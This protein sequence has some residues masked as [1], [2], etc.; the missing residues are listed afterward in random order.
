MIAKMN[1]ISITGPKYD[2][3]RV[4]DTYLSKHEIH[5]ENALQ[6]LNTAKELKPYIESNPYKES[7]TKALDLVNMLDDASGPSTDINVDY[8]TSLVD[9]ITS[10]MK[11][12][13]DQAD[14]LKQKYDSLQA[15]YNKIAPFI[16]LHYDVSKIIHFDYIRYRFGRIPREYWSK[17]KDYVYEDL[18]TIF[19]ECKYDDDYV[20]GIYFV[21][22]AENDKVDAIYTSL[23]FERTFIPDEY[24]GTPTEACENLQRQMNEVSLEIGEMEQ[25]IANTL[26]Y[27]KPQILCAYRKI[28]TASDNFDYRK[29]A[30]CTK[31]GDKI[32]YILCGWIPENEAKLLDQETKDD[33]D[34]VVILEGSDASEVSTPPTK[35]QNKGIFKPFEMFIRMYGLPAYDEFDPTIFV[36]LTYAFIFGAMFGDVGQGL[37][38]FIGGLLLYKFKHIPLAAIVSCAGICSTFFGFMFGSIFGFENII[39]PVWLRPGAAMTN[40]RGIGS[41][42]TVFIVAVGFGMCMILVSMI[43]NIINCIRSKD[44]GNACFD[45]NGIAGLVFYGALVLTIVLFL[46]GHSL[47]ATIVLIIIFVI[48]LLI[49][50]C[51]EPLTKL[52]EK[53]PDLFPEGKGMFVIMSVFE[54]IEVLLSYFSNTISFIRIGAF[55][56]SHAAMMEVV[57]MLA[58]AENGGTGNLVVIILGNLFVMGMEGLIVGIQVLRLEYY[59]IFSRFYKGTGREFVP[60]SKRNSKK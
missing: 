30:A 21:P 10:Q 13:T 23:H 2:M 50:A 14:K 28:Q 41:L 32:Y 55:A 5:L 35:L 4:I 18:S 20:W 60:F 16:G 57:L 45:T 24:N 47:P 44:F 59:E 58:G 27:K 43:F 26:A 34:V 53:K 3:D 54:L 39:K 25:R 1:F 48:P 11:E 52:I 6:E 22:V 12:L 19:T 49:I 46:T 42:N 15:S 36:A 29:M 56:V 33:A 17:F 31:D 37:C 8:A 38:L 40:L 7:L 9:E 51:K